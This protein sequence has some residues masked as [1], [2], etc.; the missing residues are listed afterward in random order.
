ML[1]GRIEQSRGVQPIDELSQP[2]ETCHNWQRIP[3]VTTTGSFADCRSSRLR[4][5]EGL[6]TP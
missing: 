5:L 2:I 4:Y 1:I 3:A 6:G